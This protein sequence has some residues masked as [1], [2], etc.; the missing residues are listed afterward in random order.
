MQNGF[1]RGRDTVDSAIVLYIILN[2]YLEQGKKLYTFF[3]DYS[4]AFDYF[5]HG[6]LWYKLLNLGVRGKIIDIIRFMYSQ[7]RTKVF[8]NNET[9]ETFTFNWL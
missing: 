4:K 9:S 2:E 5:V 7:V 6:N 3:I 8:K 1:R